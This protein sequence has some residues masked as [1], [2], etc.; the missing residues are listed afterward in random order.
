[1]W[2]AGI[3]V[4]RISAELGVAT[5][6]LNRVRARLGLPPRTPH[7][8]AKPREPYRDPTPEEIAVRSA[9]IRR[10]WTP[11]IEEKRRVSK[12]PP[13]Y[14]FPTVRVEDLDDAMREHL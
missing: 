7:T 3:S 4:A 11:E 1:M 5:D 6:S 14:E 13:P 12:T 8:R 9:A 10:T 2:N